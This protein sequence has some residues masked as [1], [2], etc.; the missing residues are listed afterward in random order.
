MKQLKL[1][2]TILAG[3]AGAACTLG[4]PALQ[5]AAKPAAVAKKNPYANP[6][7]AKYMFEN[8]LKPGMTGY[9]L[10]VMHGVKI[11]KFKVTI[12]DVMSNFQPDMNVILVRC[13]GLGLSKSGII[14]GMSGSPVYI[15]GR[16]IG[17]IAYGWDYSRYPLG[18]VQPIRQMLQIP[19]PKKGKPAPANAGGKLSWVER[20]AIRH[21]LAGWSALVRH[22]GLAMGETR[23]QLQRGGDRA[24]AVAGNLRPL[25][26]PLEVGGASP[27]VLRYLKRAYH[28]SS[29][30]PVGGGGSGG[31]QLLGGMQGLGAAA[32][33]LVPGAAI[34]VPLLTGD[35][36]MGAIGTVTDV[37]GDHV[38]AF[39]HRFFNV[40]RNGL[41]ISGAYI[42][43]IIARLKTSFKLGSTF[44]IQGHL[45]MDQ[46]CGIVGALA[47]PAKPVPVIVSVAYHNPDWHHVFHYHLYPSPHTTA[48]ALG[49]ALI[50]SMTAKRNVTGKNAANYTV[51]ITGTIHFGTFVVH[52]N[53]RSTTG[54]FDPNSVLLPVALLLNN[55]FRN[56]AISE[57]N[58]HVSLR[59]TNHAAVITSVLLEHHT[60]RPGQFLLARVAIKP[61]HGPIEHRMIRLRVPLNTPDGNYD[62]AVGADSTAMA[63]QQTYFPQD[64]A[65]NSIADLKRDVMRIVSYQNNRIYARLVLNSHGL[66]SAGRAMPNLP[67]SRIDIIMRSPG[68]PLFPLFNSVEKR[69]VTPWVITSGGQEFQVMVRHRADGRFFMAKPAMAGPPGLGG[70]LAN[71]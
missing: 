62:F 1:A 49:G 24:T 47:P 27:A 42:Y 15:H 50:A 45:V 7:P 40:G 60:V 65:P 53:R 33:R 6:D 63:Q 68:R 58:L 9:G 67:A 66:A 25:A 26:T 11:Q 16:L 5:A 41:P 23:R 2:L 34:G 8:E 55:P 64:F 21:D 36:N 70:N 20:T 48:E 4:Q 14:E 56:L 51:H 12:V 28:E 71:P 61:Y 52:L 29:I 32:Y 18:G 59:A 13:S 37:V 39:G 3:L 22:V 17:A 46:S 43:T 19:L 35:T 54:G 31:G 69:L 57:A 44:H 30:I 38:Y 10:T